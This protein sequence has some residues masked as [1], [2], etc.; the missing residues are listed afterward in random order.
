[1]LLDIKLLSVL[2]LSHLDTEEVLVLRQDSAFELLLLNC[3]VVQL[4][5]VHRRIVFDSRCF[6]FHFF[7]LLLKSLKSQFT[8]VLLQRP[9]FHFLELVLVILVHRHVTNGREGF[10]TT[11]PPYRVPRTRGVRQ[12]IIRN[13]WLLPCEYFSEGW[14]F[15]QT[16]SHI[17]FISVS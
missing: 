5:H 17:V 16:L 12:V 14:H 1:M 15:I 7:D 4:H 10:Q 6:S 13:L 8:H 9:R 11:S 2:L 3:V